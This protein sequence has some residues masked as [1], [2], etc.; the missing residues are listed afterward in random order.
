MYILLLYIFYPLSI[1]LLECELAVG[2]A[3]HGP[4][5]SAAGLPGAAG[6]RQP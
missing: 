2:A 6:G 3:S 1:C 5:C 4:R